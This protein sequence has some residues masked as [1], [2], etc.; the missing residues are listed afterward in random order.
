MTTTSTKT[1]VP[2]FMFRL[3]GG[4]LVAGTALFLAGMITSPAADSHSLGD[5][6]TSLARDSVLTQTSAL[7]L[8]YGNLLIGTGALVLP[9][10]VRGARGRIVTIVGALLVTLGF[11]NTSGAVLSDWWNMEVGRQLPLDRAVSVA[12]AVLDAPGLM[13]WK[14]LQDIGLIGVVIVLAGLARAGVVRW[15]LVPVPLVFMAAAFAVPLSLPLL[16]SA[17][18]ALALAPLAA[19]GVLTVRRAG[20]AAA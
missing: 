5:Y 10:L 7:L 9:F 17:V 11:L 4:A 18:I 15:W 16:V 14:G 6:I 3:G 8:H 13:A 12:Q 1:P 19:V 2:T 20:L